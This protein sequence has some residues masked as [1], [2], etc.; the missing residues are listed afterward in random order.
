MSASA[1]PANAS[2]QAG[3]PYRLD[4]RAA[5][6]APALPATTAAASNPC[7]SSAHPKV[8][9]KLGEQIRAAL[10]GRRGTESVAVYDRKRGIYCSVDSGRH[11]DSA[12]VVKATILG[13]L[14]R[15]V[16]D[17]H[18]AMTRSE[19]SLANKMITR[20]DNNAA[21]ALWRSVGRTRMK[22]FLKRAGMTHTTLG[23]GGY[24]GLTQITA[25]DEMQL[26]RHLTARNAL[27][28]DKARAYALKLMNSVI[29][30]QRWG[31]PSGRPAGTK[32]HVKNGWLPRHNKYWRVHSI[33]SFDG[34]GRDYMIVVL[35]RDTPSM[36]YG[37]GTIERVAKVVHRDLNPGLRSMTTEPVPNPTFERSD[38]SVPADA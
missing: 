36:A 17:Q 11:Y 30:S 4:A 21:S 29:R 15:K 8:A 37:V 35:T 1:V 2:P 28:P 33:G 26:L 38:G 23:S 7:R 5:A 13:A 34:H 12:S 3:A 20:S 19:K 6:A 24:W 10:R 16:T 31:T 14:L 32:W 27:L 18:R 22:R 25:H 9:K